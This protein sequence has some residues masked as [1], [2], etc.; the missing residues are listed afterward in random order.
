MVMSWQRPS[1]LLQPYSRMCTRTRPDNGRKKLC[2][3]LG[4][5]PIFNA[6][7][8]TILTDLLHTVGNWVA[9]GGEAMQAVI[10]KQLSEWGV[11]FWTP[12]LSWT[13]SFWNGI[14]IRFKR[15]AGSRADVVP[16]AE[17]IEGI[18][19]SVLSYVHSSVLFAVMWMATYVVL[20]FY[21][22]T[23]CNVQRKIR[24]EHFRRKL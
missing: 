16:M 14:G 20:L 9:V 19:I 15:G 17:A 24:L 12:S 11:P 18:I 1:D 22:F 13:K 21:N 6:T 5:K 2:G 7:Q 4:R 10:A 8:M 3:P 23:A